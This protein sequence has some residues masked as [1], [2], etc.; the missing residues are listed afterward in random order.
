MWRHHRSD[1][2]VSTRRDAAIVGESMYQSSHSG[3]ESEFTG[4][5]P[6]RAVWSQRLGA[7]LL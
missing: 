2:A 5:L 1:G 4:A 3:N 6:A 7:G